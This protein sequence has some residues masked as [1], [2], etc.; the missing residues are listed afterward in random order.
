M[1]LR[2]YDM[3]AMFKEPDLTKGIPKCSLNSYP[4]QSC[5]SDAILPHEAP[6]RT[7]NPCDCLLTTYQGSE[8][9]VIES[10]KDFPPIPA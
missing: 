10:L 8:A 9:Y 5:D 2:H 7:R 1:L 3:K 6:F 4:F